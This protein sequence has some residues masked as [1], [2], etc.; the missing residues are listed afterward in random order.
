MTL[1]PYSHPCCSVDMSAGRVK[2]GSDGSEPSAFLLVGIL[3]AAKGNRA[4]LVPGNVL[5]GMSS[6]VSEGALRPHIQGV[7][8]CLPKSNSVV[9][10]VS[11]IR[12]R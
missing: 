9:D 8:I 4:T 2:P 1:L 6:Y 7:G 5:L 12:R 10:D 11:I 3:Y